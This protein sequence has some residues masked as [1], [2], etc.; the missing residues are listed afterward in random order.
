MPVCPCAFFVLRWSR[1]AERPLLGDS[2][3]RTTAV[4]ETGRF[5]AAQNAEDAANRGLIGADQAAIAQIGLL[6]TLQQGGQFSAASEQLIT[7]GRF[8][9]ECAEPF[10]I[11]AQAGALQQAAA[12]VAMLLE[13]GE[14]R[15]LLVEQGIQAGQV[16]LGECLGLGIGQ[17]KPWL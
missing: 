13:Q 15:L 8:A 5:A 1:L 11:G 4:I 7:Y 6:A 14:Q 12:V 10:L 17:L 3:G 9:C 2:S 16:T